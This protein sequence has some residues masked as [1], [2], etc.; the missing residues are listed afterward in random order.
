MIAVCPALTTG[1]GF[2]SGLLRHIDCQ[3]ETIGAA[4][5]AAL[6][7]PTSPASL[8]LTALMTIFIA[9]FGIR[10]VLGETP[11]LRDG[12]MAMAKIG[13]VLVIATSWP[14]YR[15]VVYDVIVDG[16]SEL[17]KR[18]G[19]AAGLPGG[20]GA[21][22]DRLQSTD[23]AFVRLATF[24]SGRNDLV[25]RAP[26]SRTEGSER[27]PLA[28]DAGFGGA[29]LIFLAATVASFGLLRLMAGLLLALAPLF[30]GLLLFDVARGLF[31]GWFRALVF[32]LLGSVAVTVVL[33]VELALLEPWLAQVLQLRA[34]RL[35]T[36]SAPI[37]LLVV[38]LAFAVALAGS[39]AVIMRLAFY[40]AFPIL[41]R[42]AEL[43]VP[44][45]AQSS[46]PR[47][48]L[49]IQTARANAETTRALSVAHSLG[50][51]QRRDGARVMT[52]GYGQTSGVVGP[53]FAATDEFSIPAATT[54]VS[55]RTRPR[56][57]VG[58]L[59]RDRR[60]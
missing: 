26:E 41:P 13:V 5:Y 55:R 12:V 32:T 52:A 8:V 2:L 24:G 14:A 34:A 20:E 48:D 44:S 58:G 30:A 28:D 40:T 27:E 21:L 57:S 10:M 46:P 39:L 16:P 19:S 1:S 18:L 45:A 47:A 9:L 59:L 42:F 56:R 53:S 36:A 51:A 22:I 6:A 60:S 7:D 17:G 38:T 33:G 11:S 49:A 15:T 54:P 23:R 43:V 50:A 31:V 25:S 29:R 4:G 35:I 37:E 3:A